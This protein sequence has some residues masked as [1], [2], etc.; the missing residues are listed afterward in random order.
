[1][2]ELLKKQLAN[3]RVVLDALEHQIDIRNRVE[4][5]SACRVSRN[6]G[7]IQACAAEAL[8]IDLMGTFKPECFK[9]GG[10]LAG[11]PK[12]VPQAPLPAGG[13]ATPGAE[14]KT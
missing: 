8:Q 10:R 9:A 2:I 12:P 11:Q 7:R 5:Q 3:I 6:L 14:P 4:H 13:P 1:M